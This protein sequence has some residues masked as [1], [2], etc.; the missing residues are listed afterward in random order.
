M[1]P[2]VPR[3]RFTTQIRLK[4]GNTSDAYKSVLALDLQLKQLDIWCLCKEPNTVTANV[5]KPMHK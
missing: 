2:C 1:K 4:L 5:Y 3:I